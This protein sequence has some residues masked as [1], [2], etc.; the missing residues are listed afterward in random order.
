[1]ATTA[2]LKF[3]LK[4][5]FAPGLSKLIPAG[6][7]IELTGYFQDGQTRIYLPD[8]KQPLEGFMV[9]EAELRA[10]IR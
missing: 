4:G 6:E 1:M 3:P 2:V 9:S 10:A 5:S 7:R 8:S